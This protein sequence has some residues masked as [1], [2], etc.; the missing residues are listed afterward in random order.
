MRS[1]S[2]RVLPSG[3]VTVE[4]EL[5]SR[6][7]RRERGDPRLASRG[8][9]H[10]LGEPHGGAR[11]E[12]AHADHLEQRGVRVEQPPLGVGHVEPS[13]EDPRQGAQRLRIVEGRAARTARR[14]AGGARLVIHRQSL[15]VVSVPPG[16]ACDARRR[17]PRVR[18][19][20]VPPR[21]GGPEIPPRVTAPSLREAATNN[22]TAVSHRT[23]T[24]RGIRWDD[25]ITPSVTR[26]SSVDGRP[27]RS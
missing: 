26:A 3:S 25:R 12:R 20:F 17:V 8:V 14:A 27:S 5:A 6:A 15:Q 13:G 24:G 21:R 18:R 2:E 11:V 22:L 16:R 1:T 7:A 23:Q 4:L 10:D 9:A 19:A